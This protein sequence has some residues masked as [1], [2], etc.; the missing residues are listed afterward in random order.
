MDQFEYSTLEFDK[1]LVLLRKFHGVVV[2]EDIIT[3][4]EYMFKNDMITDRHIGVVNDLVD[5][6]LE[7]KI[8]CFNKLLDYMKKNPVFFRL[9]LAVVCDT[10]D[11]I[12]FPVLGEFKVKELRIKPF[13]TYKAAISW[14]AS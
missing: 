8:G 10:P 3:S 4:W 5:A 9:K 13:T 6:T 1:G 11:K 2:V 12:I 7:M 14:I